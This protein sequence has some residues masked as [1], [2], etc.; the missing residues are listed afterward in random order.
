MLHILKCQKCG[1]YTLKEK[2]S[3]GGKAVSPRPARFSPDDKYA[4]Y[5]RKVKKKELEEKGLL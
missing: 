5:R 1:K 3:C 2:C 4:A